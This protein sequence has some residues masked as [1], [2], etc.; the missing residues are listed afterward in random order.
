MEELISIGKIINTHGHLGELKILPLTD[1]PERFNDTE[2]VVATLR[3][4][5]SI[6]HPENVRFHKNF[7]IIKFQ[8]I[9]DMNTAL[10][11]KGALLQVPRSDLVQLPEGHYY[12]FEL[13][14]ISVFTV[15]GV[16]LGQITDIIST[17]SNDV[18][19]VKNEDN[20]E[21]LIPALKKVVHE[22][23]IEEK[24]MRVQLLEELNS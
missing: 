18:Y 21:I 22:I 8:E 1:F 5:Q 19:V 11:Y 24:K 13:L 12:V 6:L 23:N 15:E 4:K 2:K 14:G 9:T 10:L 16:E 3:D 7:V 17:G 20:K